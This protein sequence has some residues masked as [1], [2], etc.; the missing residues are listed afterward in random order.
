MAREYTE[1]DRAL[2]AKIDAAEKAL[3]ALYARRANKHVVFQWW[4]CACGC[5]K[6]IR[7]EGQSYAPPCATCVQP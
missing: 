3:G 6:Q 5:T 1:A 4:W 7:T 2:D